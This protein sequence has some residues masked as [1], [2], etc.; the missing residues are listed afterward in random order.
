MR[1]SKYI[2]DA[3]DLR[4]DG[5]YT[6]FVNIEKDDAGIQYTHA[7]E[8]YEEVKNYLENLENATEKI[9]NSDA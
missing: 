6:Y 2:G 7:V 3:F 9:S 5:D 1:F 4:N 8:F